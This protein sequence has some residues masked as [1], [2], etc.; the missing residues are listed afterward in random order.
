MLVIHQRS[1]GT[2]C[3]PGVDDVDVEGLGDQLEQGLQD[4]T[5][6]LDG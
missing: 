1:W 4:A 5:G 2:G 3:A 6:S